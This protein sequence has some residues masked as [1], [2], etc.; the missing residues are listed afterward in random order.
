MALISSALLTC[1]QK[2]EGEKEFEL[3]EREA[4]EGDLSIDWKV[5]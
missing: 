3:I 1:E 5:F 2:S 4:T